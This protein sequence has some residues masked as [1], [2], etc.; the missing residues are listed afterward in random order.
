[1]NVA[2]E[3]RDLADDLMDVCNESVVTSV[4]GPVVHHCVD[5][6]RLLASWHEGVFVREENDRLKI[7]LESHR[8]VITAIEQKARSR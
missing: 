7:Q 5:H 1:M 4:A 6:L 2:K 3:L 8:K